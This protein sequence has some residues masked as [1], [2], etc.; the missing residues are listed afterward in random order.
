[1]G[2]AAKRWRTGTTGCRTAL[3]AVLA[4][5]PPACAEGPIAFRDVTPHTGIAFRHTDGGS[6]RHYIVETFASGLATFDYDGDGLV[7]V[8]FLNGRP[9]RG[10]EPDPPPTNA[11][12]RNLGGFRF[13]DVTEQAGVGD[14]GHG[15]GVCV[16]DYDHDGWLDLFMTD[17]EQ[18]KPILYRNL[19]NG[20]FEDATMRAGAAIREGWRRSGWT[21][22][23]ISPRTRS[24]PRAVRPAS[25]SG[26]PWAHAPAA[27]QTS[28]RQPALRSDPPS[29]RRRLA[30]EAGGD[31]HHRDLKTSI[32]GRN[33]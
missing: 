28:S 18:Q 14:P 22:P 30:P 16:G 19:G 10:A 23:S 15:L 2:R 27:K 4:L 11:L 17:F 3:A 32:K 33:R 9:L 6:G 13:A 26:A 31:A 24:T 7:D 25:A 5:L 20:L 29:A 1:M 12:Y 8:Y 21:D